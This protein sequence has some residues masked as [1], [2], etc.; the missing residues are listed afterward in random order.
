MS[1][2]AITGGLGGRPPRSED[3]APEDRRERANGPAAGARKED[4]APAPE[5]ARQE[6]LLAEL[7]AAAQ[8]V[9]RTAEGLGQDLRAHRSDFT[10][11]SER[12]RRLENRGILALAVA[13]PVA[14][15]ALGLLL[16]AE[17]GIVAARDPS[18][19]WRD[20]VWDNHGA[21]VR[22][23]AERAHRTGKPVPCTVMVQVR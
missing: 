5:P 3:P 2:D 15:V 17:L 10:R 23:C 21:A 22:E 9:V 18:G 8:A 11:W 14:F 12:H 19:G 13:L 1:A 6:A 7:A 16:Q 4:P 20:W